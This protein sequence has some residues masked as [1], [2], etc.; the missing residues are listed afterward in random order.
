MNPSSKPAISEAASVFL[1]AFRIVAALTV[2][3]AH[4]GSRWLTAYPGVLTQLS[5]LSHVAV[6]VFF[7]ISGYV[8]A[9]SSAGRGPRQFAI[10]RLSRLYAVLLPALLLMALIEFSVRQTDAALAAPYIRGASI[11]RYVLCLLFSN[12][13]GWWSAAPPINTPL[14]SLSFEFWFYVLFGSWHYGRGGW[15]RAGLVGLAGLVAGPK[16]LLLLPVWLFG[17][18]AYRWPKPAWLAGREWAVVLALLGLTALAV[19]YVPRGPL[20][21]GEAPLFLAGQFLTDW[22]VG[23]LFALA[24]WSLPASGQPGRSPWRTALRT[25]ADLSFPLYVLHF[26]LLM[27]WLTVFGRQADGLAQL[28]LA[29]TVITLLAAGLGQGLE[30]QRG[31]WVRLIDRWL[32]DRRR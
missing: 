11:P 18:A 27:L 22:V 4:A 32:P 28:A 8:I 30:R 3:L 2:V 16:I 10:A 23:L 29:V 25:V 1:D 15:R 6:V 19:A 26:P 7:V 5:R 14:W 12:E 13:I 31:W 17:V 20:D 21:L 24:V 9:F